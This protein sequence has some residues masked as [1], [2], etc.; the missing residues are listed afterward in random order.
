VLHVGTLD[1]QICWNSAT[2]SDGHVIRHVIYKY[3]IVVFLGGELKRVNI[4]MFLT[5]VSKTL[6]DPQVKIICW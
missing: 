4:I 3:I 6:M 1:S 2:S 5:R